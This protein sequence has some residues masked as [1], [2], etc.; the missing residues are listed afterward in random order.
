MDSNDVVSPSADLCKEP[1]MRKV[2]VRNIP[3]VPKSFISRLETDL[4]RLF[5]TYG[6]VT[7]L[8]LVQN[9]PLTR[10]RPPIRQRDFPRGGVRHRSPWCPP[11]TLRRKGRFSSYR[12]REPSKTTAVLPNLKLPPPPP[13]KS[14]W[15]AYPPTPPE[16]S[17]PDEVFTLFAPFGSINRVVVPASKVASKNQGFALVRF[18]TQV[19]PALVLGIGRLQLRNKKVV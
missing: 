18:D 14:S 19:D 4:G 9:G 7:S 1:Q 8:R 10:L 17:S 12:S 11:H 5:A 6:N 13:S 3:R 16:V 2:H 15:G